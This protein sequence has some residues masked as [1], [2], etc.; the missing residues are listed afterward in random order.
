[1]DTWQIA[2][3]ISGYC[4]NQYPNLE[5]NVNSE[6]ANKTVICGVDFPFKV[7]LKICS[8]KRNKVSSL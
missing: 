8:D 2:Y 7:T 3:K 1:M 4:L 6:Y 5:W